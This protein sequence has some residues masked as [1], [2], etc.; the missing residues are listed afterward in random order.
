[1]SRGFQQKTTL[2]AML[3]IWK[4]TFPLRRVFC[5][6]KAFKVTLFYSVMRLCNVYSMS[7]RIFMCKEDI[8]VYWISYRKSS[9]CQTMTNQ[10]VCFSGISSYGDDMC[11]CGETGGCDGG[12][13]Q[14]CSCD[15][16]DKKRRKDGGKIVNVSV[17][18]FF[19]VSLHWYMPM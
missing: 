10:C 2:E 1:M 5:V 8:C 17:G 14:K 3:S 19:N 15:E 13:A 7:H 11:T 12:K 4:K 6:F 18:F 9:R 16:A